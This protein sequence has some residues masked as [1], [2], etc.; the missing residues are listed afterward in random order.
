MDQSALLRIQNLVG[1]IYKADEA[2]ISNQWGVILR[3]IMASVSRGRYDRDFD[4]TR[5][6]DSVIRDSVFEDRWWDSERV[7]E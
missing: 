2:M 4:P 5:P 7:F 1:V 6:W 3:S